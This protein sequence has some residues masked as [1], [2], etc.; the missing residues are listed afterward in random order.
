MKKEAKFTKVFWVG[1]I[2]I[3][4]ISLIL[5]MV[6]LGIF[7]G[8]KKDPKLPKSY[9]QSEAHHVCPAPEK[10]YIHDTVEIKVPQFCNRKHVD[11]SKPLT[12]ISET[13]KD[14]GNSGI[15]KQDK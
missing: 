11:E 10:I 3:S 4:L 1:I 14:S 13:P 6:I 8:L 12:T 9:Q 5:L 2:P 15:E 7:Y